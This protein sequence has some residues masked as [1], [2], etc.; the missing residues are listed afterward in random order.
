MPSPFVREAEQR[1]AE[2]E[3]TLKKVPSKIYQQKLEGAKETYKEL[4]T[5]LNSIAGFSSYDQLEFLGATAAAIVR[6]YSDISKFPE[7]KDALAKALLDARE[8]LPPSLASAITAD[9]KLAVDSSNSPLILGAT[10][11]F[12]ESVAIYNSLDRALSDFALRGVPINGMEGFRESLDLLSSKEYAPYSRDLLT[13]RYGA[14]GEG[15]AQVRQILG[16]AESSS[17]VLRQYNEIVSALVIGQAGR[18]DAAD[19]AYGVWRN[20]ADRYP[21][22]PGAENDPVARIAGA[23]ASGQ[24]RY[25]YVQSPSTTVREGWRN[26]FDFASQLLAANTLGRIAQVRPEELYLSVKAASVLP[27]GTQA[28]FFGKERFFELTSQFNFNKPSGAGA[29]AMQLAIENAAKGDIYG[30]VSRYLSSVYFL[31]KDQ[32]ARFGTINSLMEEFEKAIYEAGNRVEEMQNRITDQ[33][34]LQRGS[35]EIPL[36]FLAQGMPYVNPSMSAA[37]LGRL[38]FVSSFEGMSIPEISK[39]MSPQDSYLRNNLFLNRF[40]ADEYLKRLLSSRFMEITSNRNNLHFQAGLESIMAGL[41]EKYNNARQRLAKMQPDYY[42]RNVAVYAGEGRQAEGVALDVQLAY[43]GVDPAQSL[44][45]EGYV[46]PR[47]GGQVDWMARGQMTATEVLG[48]NVWNLMG[49][50]DQ[51][52]REGTMPGGITATEIQDTYSIAE[53]DSTFGTKDG[54]CRANFYGRSYV[55]NT[56][57][58]E[59]YWGTAYI[60]QNGH[61]LKVVMDHDA[62]VRAGLKDALDHRF[63]MANADFNGNNRL[64][65][66]LEANTYDYERGGYN[67]EA[68]GVMLVGQLAPVANL[69]AGGA[70]SIDREQAAAGSVQ[71]GSGTYVTA[72]TY[73][74]NNRDIF[75]GSGTTFAQTPGSFVSGGA[76]YKNYRLYEKPIEDITSST[77]LSGFEVHA[78]ELFRATV[79]GGHKSEGAMTSAIAGAQVTT[80]RNYTGGALEYGTARGGP[81]SLSNVDRFTFGSFGRLPGMPQMDYMLYSNFERDQRGILFGG[82]T[83]RFKDAKR[84]DIG[85]LTL[86]GTSNQFG[87]LSQQATRNIALQA[88]SLN[89]DVAAIK[90]PTRENTVYWLERMRQIAN[91]AVSEIP[92][93]FWGMS[94]YYQFGIGYS[95]KRTAS[96]WSDMDGFFTFGGYRKSDG[97]FQNNYAFAGNYRDRFALFGSYA[98]EIDY[99]GGVKLGFGKAATGFY[100]SRVPSGN[101]RE[102]FMLGTTDFAARNLFGEGQTS[103]AVSV[104]ANGSY[105]IHFMNVLEGKSDEQGKKGDY[106]ANIDIYRYALPGAPLSGWEASAGYQSEGFDMA[107]FGTQQM[108]WR[109]FGGFGQA[110]G[111]A[112]TG[113]YLDLNGSVTSGQHSFNAGLRAMLNQNT[114]YWYGNIGYSYNF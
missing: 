97:T 87:Q 45:L 99:T 7:Y 82:A 64:R 51:Y 89:D 29:D 81:L 18:H 75:A 92:E 65:G 21:K 96:S 105:K 55:T 106:F 32:M 84:G 93:R 94:A 53:L 100:L 33:W 16:L 73:R 48:V 44:Q 95:G 12:I 71:V 90:S 31:Q 43:K 22:L 109:M 114:R 69:V 62:I 2:E 91:L 80:V 41:S 61:W 26:T 5:H 9:G 66:A 110:K 13:S 54:T 27:A 1:K 85:A 77:F 35:I 6:T 49:R 8:R 98:S 60:R 14:K 20:F 15:L 34:A 24:V 4:R 101:G 103:G 70:T 108:Y 46:L 88:K 38:R 86:F 52:R 67:R 113:N 58:A 39:T 56:D 74:F 72:M 40:Y 25:T 57:V 3:P 28:V 10:S 78:D 30:V 59:T 17:D 76:R 36:I 112:F 11:K 50:I 68:T 37:D 63:A 79:F 47:T 83:Y 42:Q 19:R 104:G 111:G 102:S 107:L 23:G